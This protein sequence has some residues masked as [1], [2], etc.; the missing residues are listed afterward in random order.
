MSGMLPLIL[1]STSCMDGARQ[2]WSDDKRYQQPGTKEYQSREKSNSDRLWD[3][4]RQ[5]EQH[6][7]R[8]KRRTGTD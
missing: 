7:K 5:T 4:L 2:D 6:E 1:L 3:E 8:E